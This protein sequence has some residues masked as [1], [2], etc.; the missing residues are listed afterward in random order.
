MQKYTKICATVSDKRLQR[1]ILKIL[2]DAG[3]NVVEDELSP[4]DYEGLQKKL[5]KH[6]AANKSID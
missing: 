1:R 3:V 4:P 6:R 2:F 5:W